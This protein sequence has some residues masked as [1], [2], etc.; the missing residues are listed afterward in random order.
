MFDLSVCLSLSGAAAGGEPADVMLA[1]R[2]CERAEEGRPL[3]PRPR[4]RQ[5]QLAPAPPVGPMP[6]KTCSIS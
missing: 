6:G 1:D 3:R 2:L 4:P 5:R